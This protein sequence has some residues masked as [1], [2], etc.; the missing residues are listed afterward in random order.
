MIDTQNAPTVGTATQLT[1]TYAIMMVDSD[2]PPNTAGGPTSELLHWM[3][4]GLVSAN[5]ST[6]IGG[7][8]VFELTNPSNTAAIA[9][10]IAPA[11]PNKSPT[12]HRYTQMLL[13]TDTNSSVLQT[14]TKLGANRANFS[15]VNVVK[16]A[17]LTVL[18]GN[19][20]NVTATSATT[21]IGSG[22]NTFGSQ[23]TAASGAASASGTSTG[24]PTFKGD[25]RRTENGAFIAVLG[26]FAAA[27][28]IL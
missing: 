23:G 20:F 1:G 28:M 27:M 22:N 4:A 21:G 6:T 18:A 10:Y 3:Q 8:K 24:T 26:A 7:V 2:I 12:S 17:G 15:A 11:P 13:R 14:L 9:S 19:S 25:A 16:S 5:K